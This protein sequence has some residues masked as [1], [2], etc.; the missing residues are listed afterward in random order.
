MILEEQLP[1]LR[2][3]AKSKK[4]KASFCCYDNSNVT[5]T[6]VIINFHLYLIQ[7]CWQFFQIFV[8]GDLVYA[9]TWGVFPLKNCVK[10]P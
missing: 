8:Y 3:T 10:P 7:V 5:A 6:L 2:N 4:V 1:V 9:Q